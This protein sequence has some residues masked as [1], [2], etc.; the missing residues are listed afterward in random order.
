MTA[1]RG[2]DDDTGDGTLDGGARSL[3]DAGNDEVVPAEGKARALDALG[4]G[5]G[6][7]PPEPGPAKGGA[8]G[9][10]GGSGGLLMKVAG[11]ALVSGAVLYWA[12]SGPT[13]PVDES[14]AAPTSTSNMTGRSPEGTEERHV[15]GSARTLATSTS[16]STSTSTPTPTPT[17]TST[18]SVGVLAT[19]APKAAAPKPADD[20]L[21]GELGAL[22]QARRSVRAG[23]P[24]KALALLDGYAKT[25][26]AGALRSEALVL[27]VEALMKAG[28]EDDAK[29]A[30]ASFLRDH[31]DDGAS[32]RIRA[33]LSQGK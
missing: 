9:S 13:P 8:N 19:S 5:G 16:T 12:A 17:S 2:T 3:F 28:R 24:N 18:G 31:T 10:G 25:F 22:D 27:R 20:N 6:G 21:A 4:L 1:R 7:P 30:S 29:R 11:A 26:P 32:R 33:L 23:Q 15:D 14:K